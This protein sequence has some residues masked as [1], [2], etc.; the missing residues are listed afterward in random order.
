MLPQ[1]LNKTAVITGAASGLGKEVA[2]LGARMGM[3]MVLVDFNEQALASAAEDISKSSMNSSQKS[4]LMTANVADFDR[5][6]EVAKMTEES[7]GTPHFVF[8]NAGENI[9]HP[10]L[11]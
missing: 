2:K 11:F 7:F 3:N 4:I 1:F 10:S 6:K 5:M 8:N 9:L